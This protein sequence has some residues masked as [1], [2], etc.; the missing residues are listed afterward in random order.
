MK[1]V[2][3]LKYSVYLVHASP[4]SVPAWVTFLRTLI[5]RSLRLI[6]PGPGFHHSFAVLPLPFCRSVVPL[7]F[8]RSVAA[9]A[10]VRENGIGGNVF[11][12]MPLTAFKQ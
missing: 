4:T 7:P 6:I 12:L 5:A 11:A 1:S 8:F 2:P 3:G 10:V 9:V